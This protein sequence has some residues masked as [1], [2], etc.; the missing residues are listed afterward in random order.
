MTSM[1]DKESNI[2][3]NVAGDGR[4]SVIIFRQGFCIVCGRTYRLAEWPGDVARGKNCW[5]R[6]EAEEIVKQA[7]LCPE[8]LNIAN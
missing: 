6:L 7:E 2:A 1:A 3:N 5:G 4:F 8:T